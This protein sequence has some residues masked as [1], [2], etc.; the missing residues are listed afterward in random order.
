MKKD[1][2]LKIENND[3]ILQNKKD[4]KEQFIINIEK[5]Q[6]DTK[7]F[8]EVVFANVEEHVEIT[9]SK[10]SSISQLNDQ[11]LQKIANHVYDTI[12]SVTNQV[13]IKLNEDCFEQR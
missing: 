13:C 10:D 8:Y 7:T 9:I 2:N 6:F 5:L 11:K 12:S 1:Y 3:F 4:S